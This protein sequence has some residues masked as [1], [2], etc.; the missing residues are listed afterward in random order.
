MYVQYIQGLCQSRLSTADHALLLVA[1]KLIPLITRWHRPHRSHCLLLY[2]N[3]FRGTCASVKA[4]L[5]NGCVYLLINNLLPGSRCF[6]V[7]FEVITQEQAYTVQHEVDSSTAGSRWTD[8]EGKRDSKNY[9]RIS[10]WI[11]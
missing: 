10:V 8:E 11:P 3:H 5:S 4:L 1:S 2:S 6:L 7:C 9:T